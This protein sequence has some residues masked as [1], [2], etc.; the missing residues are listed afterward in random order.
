MKMAPVRPVML[1]PP[2]KWTPPKSSTRDTPVKIS[3]KIPAQKP[4]QTITPASLH[5]GRVLLR[6]LEAGDGPSIEIAW[7]K[8]RHDRVTLHDMLVRCYGMVSAILDPEGRL[9]RTLDQPGETWRLNLDR[10]SGFVRQA[11][12]QR[13]PAETQILTRIRARHAI[14]GGAA[15][16]LFPRVVDAGLL[17]GLQN[18]TGARYSVNAAIRARYQLSGAT[19]HIT[20]ITVDGQARSSGFALPSKCAL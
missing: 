19:V 1:P 10:Y 5:E 13:G 4:A 2:P 7:T 11:A 12:G 16:R 17:G 14:N 15:V 8:S 20:G 3:A 18:L 6:Q 9:F